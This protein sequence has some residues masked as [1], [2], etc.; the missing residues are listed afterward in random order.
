MGRHSKKLRYENLTAWKAI[1]SKV[2]GISKYYKIFHCVDSTSKQ[3]LKQFQKVSFEDLRWNYSH[4]KPTGYL[5]DIIADENESSDKRP[6]YKPIQM[7]YNLAV[8]RYMGER[9]SGKSA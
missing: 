1:E 9:P 5:Q 2:L 3:I 6:G 4:E 8:L 7:Q